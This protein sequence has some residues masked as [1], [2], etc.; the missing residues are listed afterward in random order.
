MSDEDSPE[1]YAQFLVHVMTHELLDSGGYFESN[2][3]RKKMIEALIEEKICFEEVYDDGTPKLTN[4]FYKV[5]TVFTFYE[6][7]L[8]KFITLA[9]NQTKFYIYLNY[10]LDHEILH[11]DDELVLLNLL[12]KEPIK[13]QRGP[14]SKVSSRRYAI[15]NIVTQLSNYFNLPLFH[16]LKVETNKDSTISKT[17]CHVLSETFN[18]LNIPITYDTIVKDFKEAKKIYGN[19]D[20]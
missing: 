9:K 6:D 4:K 10:I 17:A 2:Y 16:T 18:D 19:N 3:V 20:L 15:F 13:G 7:G 5:K 11:G 8:H 1:K 12:R 14:K